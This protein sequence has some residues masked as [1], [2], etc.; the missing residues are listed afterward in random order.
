MP[1][2]SPNYHQRIEHEF[3]VQ[4][5]RHASVKWY[6]THNKKVPASLWNPRLRAKVGFDRLPR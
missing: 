6:M 3:T 2:L 5:I 1:T 4:R